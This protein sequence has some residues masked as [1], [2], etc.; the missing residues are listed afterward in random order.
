VSET[1]SRLR[2]KALWG[3]V[4]ATLFWGLSFPLI[5]TVGSLQQE[6][7]GNS[8]SWFESASGTAVRFGGAAVLLFLFRPKSLRTVTQ[9]ELSQGLGLGLFG[10]MGLLFQVDGMAYTSASV[11]AF[12]TQ[13]YCL[14]LPIFVAIRDRRLP[15]WVLLGSCAMMMAGVSILADVDWRHFRIGRGELE[16]LIASCIFTGQILW[17][18][19]PS[20]KKNNVTNFSLVMFLT[21]A[22]ICGLVTAFV[23][24]HPF[25]I[26]TEF[27][28]G[29]ILILTL[30]IT[31]FCTLGAYMLMNH[32]QACLP[33]TE[34]GLV[35]GAEP[36][37]AS[38]FAIFVPGIL[39]A[40]TGLN[41]PN[42]TITRNLIW[43]GGLILLANT[44]IQ[45][46]ALHKEAGLR[47][48]L[49]P[50]D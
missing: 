6:K 13:A 7:L 43:G 50:Q 37:F 2:K 32:W 38:M 9:L 41:Y 34:A 33:A 4:L 26:V 5:K 28:D 27:A 10:G 16:T 47:K 22:A 15:S 14:I 1:E 35:Y 25:D 20:Y 42:E 36:M 8:N 29:K 17:L 30:L 46:N 23:T 24:A 12:L 19:R 18:E 45:I 21:I 48:E 31:I 11:S 44:I 39:S 3:L 49:K 40:W